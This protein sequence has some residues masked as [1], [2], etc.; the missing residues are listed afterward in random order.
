MRSSPEYPEKGKMPEAL[1]A[2]TTIP[3]KPNNGVGDVASLGHHPYDD[4]VDGGCN[5]S[6]F[7]Y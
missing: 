3:L 2:K 1:V 6:F 7:S 5:I 4:V